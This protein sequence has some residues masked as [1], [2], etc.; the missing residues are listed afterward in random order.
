MIIY[1]ILPL[2]TAILFL[3]LGFFVFFR[4]RKSSINLTFALVSL[5]TSWWLFGYALV[6]MTKLEENAVILAKFLYIGVTFIPTT[7]YNFTSAY[8]G[9]NRY[10]NEKISIYASYL[11]S[12]IFSIL[13]FVSPHNFVTGVY[14][15]YW[16]YQARVGLYHNIFLLFFFILYF[17][18]LSRLYKF[19]SEKNILTMEYNR[20]KI[21]LLSFGIALFGAT[22]FIPN[23]GIEYYPFGFIFVAIG[24]GGIAYAIVRHQLMDIEV[25]IK[26][27]LVFAGLFG[28][29]YA[30]F[31]VFTFMGQVFFERLVT[32]NRWVA[33]I[34]SVVVVTLLFRPLEKLLIHI[35]DK[36]LFQKKYD[37]KEL[38]RT[39]TTEV[40]TVLDLNKLTELTTQ[41]LNHIIKLKSCAILLLD[42]EA[43]EFRLSSSHGLKDDKIVLKGESDIVTF[44]EKAR[45]YILKSQEGP[46][47][48]IPDAI[49]TDMAALASELVIPLVIHD[50]VI[51]IISLGKKKSDEN[52]TQ[53]DMDILLPLAR[54]LAIALSNAELFDQ[55]SKTQ[56]E[57][58][59]REK[60]ATIGTLAAGINHEIC[61]PLGIAR[62]QCEAFLLNVRD[63]IYKDKKVEELLDQAKTIM[64]KVMKETDRATSITKKLST[65]AKPA[66]GEMEI[67]DVAREI[68]EVLS[69]VGYE[70]KLEKIEIERRF[71]P[72][73]ARIFVDKKQLQE[74][75]FNLIRNAGQAIG[76]K[77]R[78]AIAAEN[79]AG[80]VIIDLKDSGHGVPQDKI[81]E[82]FNPFFTTK[83]PGEGTGL[84][85]F[86]VRQV[87]ERNGGKV[88]LKET[89]VG[90]GT[91]FT[92]EFPQA[93]EKGARV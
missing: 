21:T 4:N 1:V 58:A 33:L 7:Y 19:K 59:Q 43:D 78:I 15:F 83:D 64:Q 13:I 85:L 70:L 27:T 45:T 34:P 35:T 22:D 54:T 5:A 30:V 93:A 11:I 9:L 90:E 71:E 23:Y 88:Y 73:L 53:D 75:L 28:T 46:S 6:Y 69:L 50:E 60:M 44:L 47:S 18:S 42:E 49:K 26:K 56:A 31:A 87:V 25:I 41:K 74:I 55:L 8:I 89:K 92:L 77:G 40:L 2:V 12:V 63:G 68:D 67:V 32:T 79:R 86:I 10:A 48:K 80:K 38:L 17:I 24:V 16:G 61:N 39:F 91:T 76:E 3:S 37:Y 57:A 52:F 65:F 84:G 20:R 82:L 36:Y 62:G 51:G 29:V 81:K 66:K 14:K 72:D